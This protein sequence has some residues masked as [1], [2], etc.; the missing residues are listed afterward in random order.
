MG[1]ARDL[2]PLAASVASD[3]LHRVD[4][5][6]TDAPASNNI[7]DDHGR[8]SCDRSIAADE[9]TD[10]DRGEAHHLAIELR[11]E[12]VL[13]SFGRHAGHADLDLLSGRGIAQLPKEIRDLKRVVGVGSTYLHAG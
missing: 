3:C 5:Q 2:D 9:M 10:L 6:A 13:T 4:E 1:A 11:D 8:D 12:D 7:G